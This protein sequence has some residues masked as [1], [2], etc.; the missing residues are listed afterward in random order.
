MFTTLIVQPIFNL[1]VVIYSLIPGHNFGLAVIIFTIVIRMLMWPLVRKQLRQAKL[2][3]KL[4]PEIKRIK[5]ESKGNRQKEQALML[6][7]YKENGVNPFSQIGVLLLQIPIM[8]GLYSGLRKLILD[9]HQ[10]IAFSYPWVQDLGWVKDLAH[11]IHLFSAN[12]FNVVDLN[13]SALGPKGLYWP[14]MIIVV[15]SAVVQYFQS[16]QLMP[17]DKQS[18]KLRDIM[19]EA[20]EGKQADNAEMNAVMG[21]NMKF[22]LPAMIL[23]FTINIASALSLYWLVSGLVAFIQQSIILKEDVKEMESEVDGSNKKPSKNVAK[24]AEAEVVET[25][26]DEDKPNRK[27]KEG[28]KSGA[29]KKQRRK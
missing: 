18:R 21:R 20:K 16:K 11:N 24:I 14:A 1:L 4:Q 3:R 5:Q 13:R 27:K 25:N 19:R 2:M 28:K 8:I 15:S 10:I 6:E 17:E 7:L 9:P 23:L 26:K 12:L 22:L 29:R